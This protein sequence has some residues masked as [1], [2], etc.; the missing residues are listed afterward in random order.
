MTTKRGF[1]FIEVI[2]VI[3]ILG[4]VAGISSE[5][6]VRVYKNYAQQEAI[7]RASIKAELAI[8]Q[9]ANRMEY[10]ISKTVVKRR[11]ATDDSIS[12]IQIAPDEYEV[13]EWVGYDVDNFESYESNTNLKPG[14]SGFADLEASSKTSIVTRGSNL[15]L[16]KSIY[17]YLSY[18]QARISNI[19]IF[20]PDNYDFN[21]IGYKNSSTAGITFVR[22]TNND[23]K[24]YLKNNLK[25]LKEQ[26]KMAWSAYAVVPINCKKD[27]EGANLCQLELRYNF[28]PWEHQDYNSA[29]VNKALLTTNVTVFRTYAT[30]NRVQIKLCVKER[31]GI[32]SSLFAVS[33]KERVVFQ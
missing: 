26:F 9:I 22:G 28:R 10:A 13:L 8:T 17:Y 20:I 16:L 14:W 2:L 33:C 7:H 23:E 5:A 24:I 3:V 27:I 21:N 32:N 6:I 12:P 25:Y 1:T 31:Y 18:K 4:I 11:S 19:A 29:R 15:S 30:E